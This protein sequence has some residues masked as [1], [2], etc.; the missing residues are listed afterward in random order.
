[1]LIKGSL[2]AVVGL[3]VWYCLIHHR[4]KKQKHPNRI[5]SRFNNFF[6]SKYIFMWF[7]DTLNTPFARAIN[8]TTVSGRKTMP[9]WIPVLYTDTTVHLPNPYHI[10]PHLASAMASCQ[11]GW[12]FIIITIIIIIIITVINPVMNMIYSFMASIDRVRHYG[13]KIRLSV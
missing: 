4:P 8:W 7:P 10:N 2:A 12:Y 13:R 1:M 11:I 5:C 3:L 9:C 6:T